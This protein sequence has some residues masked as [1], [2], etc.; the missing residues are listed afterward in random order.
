[1]PPLRLQFISEYFS[2]MA[3][4]QLVHHTDRENYIDIYGSVRKF[5]GIVPPYMTVLY[6]ITTISNVYKLCDGHP[7]VKGT[8][9]TTQTFTINICVHG[10]RQ[11]SVSSIWKILILFTVINIYKKKANT[12]LIQREFSLTKM[13][14]RKTGFSFLYVSFKQKFKVSLIIIIKVFVVTFSSAIY[15]QN[16]ILQ[17]KC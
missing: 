6:A 8:A 17:F 5:E 2:L 7:K 10:K 13:E 9:G 1:M 4:L 14:E 16:H 3:R 12:G 15:S 11:V